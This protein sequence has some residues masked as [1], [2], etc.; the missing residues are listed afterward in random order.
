MLVF[1]VEDMVGRYEVRGRNENGE[2]MITL[3]VESDGSWKH[4]FQEGY[5]QVYMG[6]TRQ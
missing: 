5:L 2:R 3:C 1:V 4:L 6:K